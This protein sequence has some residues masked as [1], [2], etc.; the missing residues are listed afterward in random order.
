M[1]A[2]FIDNASPVFYTLALL[3]LGIALVR[4]HFYLGMVSIVIALVIYAVRTTLLQG[5]YIRSQRALREAR[6]ELEE[7][8]L[9]DGLTGVANRR[10]F[11]QV[12]DEEWRR[13]IRMKHVLSLLLIDLD[14]FKSLNDR[15]GHR[16][17]DACLVRVAE[18][19]C[20]ALPR[21]GDLL[22]RYGGEEFGAILVGTG[23]EGAEV[24]AEAMLA[25]VRAL[26]V[27]N[28]SAALGIATISVG[29]ATAE[30]RVGESAGELVEASDRAL[31]RAKAKGRDRVECFAE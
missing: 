16:A 26:R 5:F 27:E 17:G 9:Q 23:R 12:M 25:A 13:A 15:Y 28:E 31:Y 21:S 8:S 20:A 14:H 6:D 4:R 22:A 7:L 19:L 2:Q 11:D 30:P 1:L 10:C 3:A 18:A 24:V 29:I